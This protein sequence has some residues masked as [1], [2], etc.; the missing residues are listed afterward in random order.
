LARLEKAILAGE[1][2]TAEAAIGELGEAALTPAGR[3]LYFRLYALML[4]GKT[5][6]IMEAIQEAAPPKEARHD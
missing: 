6:E 1:T 2:E 5:E 3:E 4:E